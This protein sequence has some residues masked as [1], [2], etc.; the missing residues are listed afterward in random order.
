MDAMGRRL[1]QVR[2]VLET[3]A[4]LLAPDVCAGCDAR[5][6]VFTVF[7]A[8]CAAT[9]APPGETRDDETAA[10][11]YGGALGAAITSFKYGG[12]VDRARP[13]AHLLRRA[14]GPLRADPPSVVVPVPLHRARLILRGFNQ[15]SLLAGPVAR[16]LAARFAPCALARTRDTPAQASLDRV[17]RRR[18]V[19]RAFALRPRGGF[20]PGDRVLLVDDVRTT[21]ATIDACVTA[22]REA[23]A[24]DVR[25]LILAV[26]DDDRHVPRA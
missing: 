12:R 13:L 1:P 19:H 11:S 21:G 24:R 22:L 10:H 14:L 23:G 7:C 8:A 18:N 4:S 3:A 25:T 17:A 26:A 20:V 6:A 9:L 2:F 15:A 16:D 5:V